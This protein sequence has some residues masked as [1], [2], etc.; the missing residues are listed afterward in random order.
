[1]VLPWLLRAT[2]A[3]LPRAVPY[4]HVE[5]VARPKP[6]ALTVAVVWRAGPWD[7]ARSIAAG[8]VSCL[9]DVPGVLCVAA[10]PRSAAADIAGWRG[11]WQ[12]CD[13][14]DALARLVAGVDLVVS[15]DTMCAHLA[16]ALGV[17]VW[18]LLACDADWRWMIDR[19][20]SPWYPTMRLFRQTVRGSW[21]WPLARVRR[22]LQRAA[23]MH[24]PGQPVLQP[25]EA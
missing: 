15:V 10:E 21:E 19:D 14:V 6:A 12:P 13:S 2:V 20:D 16:G 1:M 7:A 11:H 24:L 22:E 5:P 3:T 17:P 25:S 4:L 8:D 18:T 23:A 9:T